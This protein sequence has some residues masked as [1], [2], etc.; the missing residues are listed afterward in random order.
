MLTLW[1][2]TYIN[3]EDVGV[4]STWQPKL[5]LLLFL[6]RSY[7]GVVW[8]GQCVIVL[9]MILDYIFTIWSFFY[10]VDLTIGVK[11]HLQSL[12]FGLVVLLFELI[13]N[14]VL[15]VFLCISLDTVFQLFVRPRPKP[16]PLVHN[17]VHNILPIIFYERDVLEESIHSPWYVMN[18]RILWKIYSPR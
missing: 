17:I 8:F 10:H 3:N 14:Y 11:Q 6:I 12:R 7:L 16:L 15:Y 2:T 18:P 5:A 9:N 4:S 13:L 1:W